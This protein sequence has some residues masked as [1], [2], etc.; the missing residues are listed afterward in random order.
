MIR[1]DEKTEWGPLLQA[2]LDMGRITGAQL[3]RATGYSEQQVST[4]KRGIKPPARVAMIRIADALGYDL[5]LVPRA[6]APEVIHSAPANGSRLTRC[7]RR[8]PFELPDTDRITADVRAAT[9]TALAF[10]EDA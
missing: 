9:C 3:S 2:L 1:I 8:T 10:R 6:E 5:A 4:W 7:C